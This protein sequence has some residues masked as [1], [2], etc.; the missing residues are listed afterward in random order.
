M[1]TSRKHGIVARPLRIGFLSRCPECDAFLSI[2]RRGTPVARLLNDTRVY[3]CTKCGLR[4][5]QP[6]K[7]DPN[8]L[9]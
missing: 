2:R 7:F 4:I 3:V 8:N 6:T 9:H 5:E 1:A